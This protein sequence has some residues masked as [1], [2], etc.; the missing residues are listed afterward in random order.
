MKNFAI[1]AALA[2]LLTGAFF[3]LNGQAQAG[4]PSPSQE[5]ASAGPGNATTPV[6]AKNMPTYLDKDL[7][8]KHVDFTQFAQT[9]VRSLNRNH[10]LAKSRMKITKQSDGS[11]VARYHSIDYATVLCKVSRSKSKTIPYVAV[12]RY[13]ELVMQAVAE[14]PDAFSQA[15]FVAVSVIPNRQI[16]SYKKGSWQ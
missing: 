6:T 8:L 9:R 2:V 5:V 4:E 13:H 12:L 16:F 10:C 11:Y 15:E 3:V 1:T 7:T 14:S